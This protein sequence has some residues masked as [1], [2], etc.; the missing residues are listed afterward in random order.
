MKKC[1]SDF[2]LI[3][4]LVVIAI[5]AILAGMLLP[6]LN[7]ARDKAKAIS[8]MNNE[9]TF[10]MASTMYIDSY[11]GYLAPDYQS[12]GVGR[13]TWLKLLAQ[14]LGIYIDQS[15][16][17]KISI[18]PSA[19]QFPVPDWSHEIWGKNW[20]N[21]GANANFVTGAYTKVSRLKKASAAFYIV[22]N[23]DDFDETNWYI[24]RKE[25]KFN[26]AFKHSNKRSL[27]VGYVDGHV[28]AMQRME[29]HAIFVD[30]VSGDGVLE[31]AFWNGI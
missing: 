12:M 24:V 26:H 22:E 14:Q 13:S 9:K 28:A 1:Y 29:L 31:I 23:S 19:K 27:N 2:T 17:V 6:A 3:E 18:C 20:P 25:E 16:E 8:C 11:D 15:V 7:N 10:S 5:I 30:G 4:L 21:Y